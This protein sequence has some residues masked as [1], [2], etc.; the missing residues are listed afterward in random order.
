MITDRQFRNQTEMRL[1]RVTEVNLAQA[2]IVGQDNFGGSLQISLQFTEPM[3]SIPS[4][5]EVWTIKRD[6]N[7]WFLDKQTNITLEELSLLGA[8]DKWIKAAGTLRL[9][10][11]EVLIN[12]ESVSFTG[13]ANLGRASYSGVGEVTSGTLQVLTW[14]DPQTSGDALLDLTNPL[15]PTIV[16]AG[17]YAIDVTIRD[18][19]AGLTGQGYA[20]LLVSSDDG[21]FLFD[22]TFPLISGDDMFAFG[23]IS[24]TR[25][26]PE[27]TLLYA[28]ANQN[29]GDIHTFVFDVSIQQIG[30][31]AGGGFDW[32]DV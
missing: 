6:G 4:Q 11:T 17:I 20:D 2:I 15:I 30:N 1:F 18:Y 14:N 13:V 10:G 12:G 5:G 7:D 9:D 16:T 8:G 29:S 19:D 23:F 22:Q 25:Y 28:R 31:T 21:D 32:E 27:G 24:C 26:L 3:I